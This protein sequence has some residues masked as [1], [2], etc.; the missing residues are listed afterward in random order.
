[1]VHSA[2]DEIFVASQK[3]MVHKFK[4][5]EYTQSEACVVRSVGP[6]ADDNVTAY[7]VLPFLV[8]FRI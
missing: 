6:M 4:A 1:M 3:L 7:Q 2:E 5:H 8:S